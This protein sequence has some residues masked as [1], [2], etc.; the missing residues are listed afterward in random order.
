MS[1]TI[2]FAKSPSEL[3]HQRFSCRTYQ[4]RP[5]S[6]EDRSG[7]EAFFPSCTA[8][9]RGNQTRFRI[10]PA[11]KY[12][13]RSLPRLGTY[14]FIKDP[15]AFIVGAL[16]IS[17]GALEDFGYCMELLVL[18]ATELG[19]GSCWLGG[20][21]TKSRFAR[22]MDLHAGEEIPAVISLGYPA[23]QQAWLDRAARTYAGADQRLPWDQ[24]FFTE[25]WA[26]PIR[27]SGAG[28]SLAPLELL[29]LAPSASNKQPWRLLHSQGRWH[30]Y[31]ER[32]S[33][34]PS[35]VFGYILGIADLQQIDIGIAMAH[36]ELGLEENGRSGEWIVADPHLERPGVPQEYVI[37]WQPA[38]G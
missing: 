19:L 35:P 11:S 15:A 1:E 20:T 5:L 17:P 30:F 38:S 26:E 13:Q 6:E 9:P 25:R 2:K 36:F 23:G 18:K 10:L 12:D 22:L 8:G 37:T 27:K 33:N 16:P 21:F 7:L 34:Y 14:G 29:R 32:T 31:L 28:A 4:K 3:I 24:L